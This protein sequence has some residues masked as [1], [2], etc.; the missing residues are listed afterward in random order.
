V[1]FAIHAD[2]NLALFEHIGKVNTGEPTA[3]VHAESFKATIDLN[4]CSP[5]QQRNMSK[6]L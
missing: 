4:D 3:L 5:P 1:V 2:E 6:A